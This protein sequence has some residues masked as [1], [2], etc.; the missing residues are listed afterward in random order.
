MSKHSPF[1]SFFKSMLSHDYLK[2]MVVSYEE[3]M[4]LFISSLWFPRFQPSFLN[5]AVFHLATLIVL[6]YP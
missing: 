1:P 6:C 4:F 5:F 3:T 2:H